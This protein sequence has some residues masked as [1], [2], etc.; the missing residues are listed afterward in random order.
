[1]SEFD[2]SI[3][4]LAVAQFLLVREN[5]HAHYLGAIAFIKHFL[6]RNRGMNSWAK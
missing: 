1:M 4:G 2:E 5:M 6:C 3:I